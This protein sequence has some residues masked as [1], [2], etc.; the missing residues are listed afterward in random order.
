MKQVKVT[1]T[2]P[3]IGDDPIKISANLYNVGNVQI[4]SSNKRKLL[5]K[6]LNSNNQICGE[7]IEIEFNGNIS[8]V[9]GVEA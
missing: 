1:Y 7:T 9:I 5:V 3:L 2:Y 6:A 4:D 8:E